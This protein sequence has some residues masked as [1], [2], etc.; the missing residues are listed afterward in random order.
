VNEPERASTHVDVALADLPSVLRVAV[1][2]LPRASIREIDNDQATV[3]QR[4]GILMPRL[5]VISL[6]IRH[7]SRG[8]SEIAIVKAMRGGRSAPDQVLS[9]FE[10][11][12]LDSIRAAA[13]E[14]LL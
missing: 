7:G 8:D 3:T 9:S 11:S 2:N 1:G 5:E 13:Q 14:F 4:S 6:V 12:L 10:R